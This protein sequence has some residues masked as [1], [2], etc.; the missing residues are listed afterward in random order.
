MEAERSVLGWSSTEGMDSYDLILGEIFMRNRNVAVKTTYRADE[1]KMLT[2]YLLR[3]VYMGYLW[4]STN[5]YICIKYGQSR[6]I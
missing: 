5:D 6:M 2:T 3:L 1:Q 4:H